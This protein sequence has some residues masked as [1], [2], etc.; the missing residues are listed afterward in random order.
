[1]V[2]GLT[3]DTF[4][5][6]FQGIDKHIVEDTE[7]ARLDTGLYPSPL[8]VIEGPLMKGMSVVGDLFGA[9]KMFLPQ[10]IKSARVMKKA[11]AHLIPFMEEEKMATQGDIYSFEPQYAGKIVLATVKGDVHDIGKNIVGVVLGCNNFKIIDLGVMVPCDVILKTCQEVKADILGLSGLITPSLSEMVHVAKEMERIGL[12][13]PLLIG[14]ATTS[15]Q[16]TAV[17]IDP[18]R[19]QPVVHVLDASKSVVVCNNLLDDNQKE[20]FLDDIED[21]YEDIRS[22]HYENLK[23]KRYL[24]IEQARAKALKLDFNPIKP[25]FLGTKVFSD[26]DLSELLPFIDWKYFFDVWQL[27]G[28]YP[29]GRYPKIFNDE[30]VG[31][32]ASRLFE[33]AQMMLRQ[34]IDQRL[35][36]AT[37]IIGFYPANSV[38]DDIYVYADD[39]RTD[40]PLAVFHG[41]RQQ[42]EVEGQKHYMCIS[43]FVAPVGIQDYI[44]VFATSA[45][46]GCEKLCEQFDEDHDDYNSIMIRAL[47]DRL[48]EALAEKLHLDVR[49]AYWGYR[50]E[51]ALSTQEILKVSYDGIRPA[52]GYPTQPDHTEKLTMWKLLNIEENTGISLTDSLAMVPAASVSGLY[53]AHPQSCYFSTGKIQKD[54]VLFCLN[55]K[56]YD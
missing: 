3:S 11:V 36:K 14:G 7:C 35:L 55:S 21:L 22:D 4:Y 47:A 13:I 24:S 53:F 20:E 46:F 5:V 50:P 32:E 9:G 42:M 6:S 19:S 37:A 23:E 15:K 1:M 39:K 34:V 56:V 44:G 52:A 33:D 51:E 30:K 43:D 26:Y 28:R 45:G 38:G 18:Q 10:V 41:L 31:E 17:K 40:Q 16:H 54:Q 27:R 12:D 25:S 8:N 48:S 2:R 49:R 29:N